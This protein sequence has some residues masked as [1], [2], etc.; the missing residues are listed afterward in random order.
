MKGG[1]QCPAKPLFIYET[2]MKQQR[3]RGGR[4]LHYSCKGEGGEG[5]GLEIQH[6]F[7]ARRIEREGVVGG[8]KNCKIGKGPSNGISTKKGR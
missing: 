5:W 7:R 2:T 3:E 6:F 1:T 4:D 8:R